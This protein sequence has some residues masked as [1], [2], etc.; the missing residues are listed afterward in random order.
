MRQIDWDSKLSEEDVAW[1]RQSGMRFGPSGRDI[2]DEIRDNLGRSYAEPEDGPEDPAT[3]SAL[4]PAATA[5][6]PFASLSE[7][8]QRARLNAGA[9]VDDEGDDYDTWTKADLTAEIEA[10]N[11][12]LGDDAK[13][14]T[15]GTKPELI[16][17]LR[18][19][20]QRAESAT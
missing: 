5:G 18:E 10:R 20:D 13:M 6:V 17:R 12:D 4:D 19:D 14:S 16:A 8:E 11:S 3:K 15:S 1:L 9:V 7:E 2:E